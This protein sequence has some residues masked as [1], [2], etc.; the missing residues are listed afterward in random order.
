MAGVKISELPNDGALSGSEK[1]T[2]ID[3]GVN[4]NITVQQIADFVIALIGGSTPQLDAPSIS[5]SAG[6]GSIT[7]TLGTV[8][9][10]TDQIIEISSD[11]FATIDGSDSGTNDGNPVTISATNGTA[12]KV[13]G[14]VSATGYLD[15]DNAVASGTYT[16]TG[17]TS[18]FTATAY[19]SATDPFVN[20]STDPTTGATL[21]R[22]V[23]PA[24]GADIEIQL[25]DFPFEYFILEY[26]DTEADVVSFFDTV[27]HNEAIPGFEMRGPF[28]VGGKK[29]ITS[30]GPT[31]FDV[32]PATVTFSF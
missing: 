4:K 31:A 8:T 22:S 6:D 25:N 14:R 28:A 3:N 7:V 24:S 20:T 27:F 17:S 12:Y 15:S 2:G 9:G 18:T 10:A 32:S 11:D 30:Y 23:T 26:D 21:L 13:R 29:Y 1:L 19:H 16:P 5:A